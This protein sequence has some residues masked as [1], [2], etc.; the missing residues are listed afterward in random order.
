M[1]DLLQDRLETILSSVPV[2][3]VVTVE[4]LDHAV[5]LARALVKGGLPVVEVTLRT[6]GAFDAIRAMAQDVQGAII[7]V[8]TVLN[9][10]QM[11]TAQA[12]G[13][14]FAVSPG[15]SDALLSAA[16]KQGMPLLP[17]I[18]TASEAMRLIEQGWRFAKFFPAEAMGGVACLKALAAPLAQLRF[19][20]TGGITPENAQEYLNLS[21][22]ICVGGS[23]MLERDLLNA[24]NWDAVATA[25]AGAA[26]LGRTG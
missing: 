1:G 13:A 17:G 12:M 6:P 16:V 21:N 4:N 2:I 19:C 9:E 5:P 26:A 7:G 22:V 24:S 20:P 3:P 8:G 18:A 25:A 14:R 11:A 23:W 15:M 10:K